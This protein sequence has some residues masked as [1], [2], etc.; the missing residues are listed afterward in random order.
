MYTP[1]STVQLPTEKLIHQSPSSCKAP[2]K[3]TQHCWPT[4]P[5]IVK[6]HILCLFTHPV[7]CCCMSLGVVVQSL[8]L[9]WSNVW[10]DNSQ[11]LFC[12]VITKA[13]HNNVVSICT[14]FQH[15]VGHTC[16]LPMH[17]FQSLMGCVF[18]VMHC[19]SKHCYSGLPAWTDQCWKLLRPL[20]HS[21]TM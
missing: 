6:C 20:A 15:C 5:N 3:R 10:A 2:C 8:K 16:A 13:Q 19:R 17:G 11:P 4:F 18:P 14:A 9:A 12:S 1:V 21:L 7:A